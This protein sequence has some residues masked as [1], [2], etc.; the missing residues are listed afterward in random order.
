LTLH[1]FTVE[2]RNY[3]YL[4]LYVDFPP[5]TIAQSDVDT[6]LDGAVSGA[7]NSGKGTLKSKSAITLGQYQGRLAEFTTEANGQVPATSIKA[8]YYLVKTRLYQV[9]AV[10]PLGKLP[11][12]ADKFL[13]SFK[14]LAQ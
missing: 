14:L 2:D 4:V 12:D 11:A 1:N 13:G 10:G 6:L 7:V 5:E 8:H 3:A 9:L